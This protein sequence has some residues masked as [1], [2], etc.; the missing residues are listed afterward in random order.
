MR[1]NN[2]AKVIYKEIANLPTYINVSHE[3]MLA[4]YLCFK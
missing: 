1:Y 2:K 4:M 3:T